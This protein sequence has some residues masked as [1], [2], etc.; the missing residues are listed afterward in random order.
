MSCMLVI[1]LLYVTPLA[2]AL[3]LLYLLPMQAAK[4]ALMLTCYPNAEE[5]CHSQVLKLENTTRH[6]QHY[7]NCRKTCTIICQQTPPLIESQQ[8]HKLD[9]TTGI[10]PEWLDKS[11]KEKKTSLIVHLH[12]H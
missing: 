6:W 7:P 5:E 10:M 1:L 11:T 3:P 12:L 2:H 8:M 9:T 4:E